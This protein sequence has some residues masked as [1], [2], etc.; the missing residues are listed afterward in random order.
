MMVKHRHSGSPSD[1]ECCD[2][3]RSDGG[4]RRPEACGDKCRR[5]APTKRRILVCCCLMAC[6]CVCLAMCETTVLEGCRRMFG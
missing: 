3:M 6:A 4:E 5:R 1:S 2:E